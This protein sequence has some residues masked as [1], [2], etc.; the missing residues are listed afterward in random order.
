MLRPGHVIAI[1][2]IALLTLG[3]VMVNSAG[4][5]V[6]GVGPD[7]QSK[8][9]VTIESIVLSRSSVYMLLA[10]LAMGAAALIPIRRLVQGG[11]YDHQ[12]GDDGATLRMLAIGTVVLV[13]FCALAY[14]PGLASPRKG[15]H[16]WVSIPGLGGPDGLSMQP[17]EVAKWGMV[18]LMAWYA[19]AT[20]LRL[21][22]FWRGLVP[23]LVS[24]G[25]VSAFIVIED[26]GTGVLIAAVAC[27]V[28][29]AGGARFW[30]FLLFV[31]VGVGGIAY[32]ILT[33]EYRV[34]RIL[35][36]M[37]PYA[38]PRGIGYH[39]IQSLIAVASGGGPGR[40]L[41][42][43]VEKFGYLPEDKTDFLF[44][45]ICAELGI[46]GALVV[47]SLFGTLVWAGCMVALRERNQMLRLFVLGVIA[48]VACQAVINLAV[49]TGLAP[50]KGIAL[51]LLSS[52]GTG[53]ILTAFCLGLIVSIDRSHAEE[54]TPELGDLSVAR[55]GVVAPE[56]VQTDH[57]PQGTNAQLAH[58]ES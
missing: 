16:R 11:S 43:S 41:G 56:A 3:V 29:L 36:F 25:V 31:P 4:M 24:I 52:G 58:A 28:L 19:C 46:P 40:G 32:A 1:V 23:A 8:V 37:D 30:H 15:A 33:S 54:S 17:S 27:L 22:E 13:A 6:S 18:A 2:A 44:A 55:V 7:G 50:T 26:L 39:T 57:V 48:T 42:H 35:A 5:S 10:V 51:P 34:K 14:M 49:V 9:G 53:W 20:G 21:R 47:A 12:S 38:D 45:I